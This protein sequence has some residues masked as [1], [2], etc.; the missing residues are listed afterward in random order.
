MPVSACGKSE[1]GSTTELDSHANI[2]VVGSQSLVIQD[3][4]QSA[5]VNAF[6]D[7]VPGMSE[8]PIVDAA[9]SYDFSI[10]GKTYSLK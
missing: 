8:V 6:S 4:G 5:H 9:I 7:E 3:T 10:T 2:I 1:Y